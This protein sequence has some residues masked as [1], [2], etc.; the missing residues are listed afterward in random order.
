MTAV[1]EAEGLGKRF[2]RQWAPTDCTLSIPAGHGV[3]LVGLNGAG[4][5]TVPIRNGRCGGLPDAI[6]ARGCITSTLNKGHWAF[7]ASLG[8]ELRRQRPQD[9]GAGYSSGWR[10]RPAG[11]RPA[12]S[13]PRAVAASGMPTRITSRLV[14]G[15]L[16]S[17]D[18][19]S[20]EL[21]RKKPIAAR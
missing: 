7:D 17:E 5:T 20:S 12:S 18:R 6:R 16:V 8:R 14:I 2:R 21:L 4:K 13:Q 1:I 19:P 15:M 9:G 10:A 11:S 3:G